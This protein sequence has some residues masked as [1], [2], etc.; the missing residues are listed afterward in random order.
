M[1]LPT[2]PQ[3]SLCSFDNSS[4][5]DGSNKA[6]NFKCINSKQTRFKINWN[7]ESADKMICSPFEDYLETQ[8]YYKK[9]FKIFE[10]EVL[11][12]ARGER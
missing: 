9:I 10:Q 2:P 5:D 3:T 4:E 6:P 11:S 7:S 1:N 8:E 12:K